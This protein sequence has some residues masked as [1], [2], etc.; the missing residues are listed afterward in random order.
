MTVDCVLMALLQF[1][2]GVYGYD[3]TERPARLR[4]FWEAFAHRQSARME[5]VPV[6]V[7]EIAPLLSVQ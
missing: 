1:A 6:F 2:Q 3:L 4:G 7:R 5:E